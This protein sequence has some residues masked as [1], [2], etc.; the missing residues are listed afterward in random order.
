V[1]GTFEGAR[2]LSTGIYRPW[3]NCE[4][5]SLNRPFC[6][7]CREAHV[8]EFTEMISLV[9]ELLPYPGTSQDIDNTGVSFSATPLPFDGL[10]YSWSLDGVPLA[11]EDAPSM[12]LTADQMSAHHQTLQLDVTFNTPLVR[13]TTVSH[14]YTWPVSTGV[15]LCCTGIVGDANFD[16]GYEP[17]I[18]DISTIV[19][20]LF[21]SGNPLACYEEADANQSGGFT[22]ESSDITISD[23]SVL[24]D[25]LFISGAPLLQC[26]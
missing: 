9:D 25:H 10:E 4:M 23:V 13:Q 6:P 12:V 24:V 16:G 17:T 20:H 7:V 21:L 3:Y 18:S 1:V 22:P 2:Y 5:R 11:G 15:T 8:L 19:D 14:S 26:F